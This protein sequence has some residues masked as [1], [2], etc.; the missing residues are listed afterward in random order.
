MIYLVGSDLKFEGVKTLVL[1][2]ISFLKF[3]VNLNNYDALIITSKNSINA[4]KFNE[5]LPVE[6]LQIYSIGKATSKAAMEFGFNKIYTAKN[7]HG[8]EFAHEILPFLAAKKVV[9]LRAK[10]TASNIFEI[11]KNDGVSIDQIIAY[12]NLYKPL[13]DEQRPPNG[14]VIIFTAPSAVR[15]FIN[16][17]GFDESYKVVAI[18]KT[19][20]NELKFAKNLK[21][22]QLQS[23]NE[24]I[25]IAKTLV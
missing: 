5:I 22:S 20:A 21:I 7:A 13:K 10:T 6:N 23:V 1:N 4:L 15:N 18:G 16:N 25:N 24:C 8:N 9:F 17:F 11:L 12:E 14:S 19:T 2:E 3:D